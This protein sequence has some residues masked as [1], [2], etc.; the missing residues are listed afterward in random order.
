MPTR[1]IGILLL[2]LAV[3]GLPQQDNRMRISQAIWNRGQ[4]MR[5]DSVPELN[6]E[7]YRLQAIYKDTEE[8][9]AL[10]TSLQTDLQQL[11]K[12]VLVKDLNQRLKKMERLAK[13][14]REEVAQ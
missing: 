14:L 9:S 5:P 4:P 3:P 13:R 1:L 7:A 12:G 2:L 11:Q 6:S 10:S 8:F